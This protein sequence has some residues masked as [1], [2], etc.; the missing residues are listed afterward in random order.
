M[1]GDRAVTLAASATASGHSALPRRWSR[2][3]A[4]LLHAASRLR[5][6]VGRVVG[7]AEC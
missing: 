7:Q 4:A 5:D 6:E 2:P 3:A 1:T